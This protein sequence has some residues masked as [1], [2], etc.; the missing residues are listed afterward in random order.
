MRP[1]DYYQREYRWEAKQV[2][3]LFNDL[4]GMFLE[5]Y[6]PGQPS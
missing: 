4:A 2:R 6:E 3:D 5:D 1:I